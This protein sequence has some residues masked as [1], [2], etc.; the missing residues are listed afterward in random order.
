MLIHAGKLLQELEEGLSKR[1]ADVY[2]E[3]LSNKILIS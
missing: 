3:I 2:L 1:A